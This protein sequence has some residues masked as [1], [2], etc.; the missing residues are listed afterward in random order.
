MA[1]QKQPQ[2]ENSNLQ[3]DFNQERFFTETLLSQ[4]IHF[5]I[6]FFIVITTGA[7]LSA[8]FA[9]NYLV[10]ILSVGTIMSWGLTL[11]ILRLSLKIRF[12]NKQMGTT[13]LNLLTSF[14][15]LPFK[16]LGWFADIFIPLVCSILLSIGLIFSM[17][18]N[19]QTDIMPNKIE[20]G[21]KQNIK[22]ITDSTKKSKGS[23]RI[24]E[25]KSIDSVIQK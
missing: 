25:F 9:K 23:E 7:I 14:V 17:T 21:I 24:K 3:I 6:I 2:G 10:L 8:S 12:I 13:G 4:R 22:T 5:F 15:K 11:S 18:G 20:Q 1:K 16:I 19:F